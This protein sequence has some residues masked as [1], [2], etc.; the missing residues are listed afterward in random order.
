[1][2]R[3]PD[4]HLDFTNWGGGAGRLDGTGG[5]VTRPVSGTV[6]RAPGVPAYRHEVPCCCL[7]PGRVNVHRSRGG[8]SSAVGTCRAARPVGPAESASEHPLEGVGRFIHGFVDRMLYLRSG[9]PDRTGVVPQPDSRAARRAS[10]G[11]LRDDFDQENPEWVVA[12]WAGGLNVGVL[13]LRRQRR[14]LSS[15]ATGQGAVPCLG[16]IRREAD[17]SARSA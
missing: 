8:R 11:C 3:P 10:D 12:S 9:R 6:P 13:Q 14:A 15:L 17:I 1:M 7:S 2:P 16:T 4:A 5:G